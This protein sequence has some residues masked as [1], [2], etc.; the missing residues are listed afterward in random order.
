MNEYLAIS[1]REVLF[2]ADTHF[3]NR[4]LPGEAVRRNRFISF[5]R[6]IP[7]GA[8]V[9]LLGDI[10]NFYFEYRSAVPKCYSDIFHAL[11][12]CHARGVQVHFLGGNHDYWT[13]DYFQNE[14]GT[15]VHK[16]S[17]RIACQ[18]KKII[19]VHGDHVMPRDVGYKVLRRVIQNRIVI[20]AATLIHPDLLDAIASGISSLSQSLRSGSHERAARSLGAG[21]QRFFDEG[22]DIFVMGHI[23]Y[24]LHVE[25]NGKQFVILGDW[26]NH[27]TYGKLLE[28]R[29]TLE[30]FRG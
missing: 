13:K 18:G 27:F 21:S 24:P 14:L 12:D 19:C 3:K 25:N 8:A 22:N 7:P 4:N 23:H 20:A 9:F 26:I 16:E 5:M 28:G 11:Y 6:Q 1:A 10:F 17:I 30:T 15:V 29:L 2:L